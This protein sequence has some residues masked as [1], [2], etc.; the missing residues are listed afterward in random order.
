MSTGDQGRHDTAPV[1]TLVLDVTK[2]NIA[3]ANRYRDTAC[4]VAANV[5]NAAGI[6]R[7]HIKITTDDQRS[8]WRGLPDFTCYYI[9]DE[10]GCLLLARDR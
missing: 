9:D 5:V 6:F 4:F 2:S 8:Q 1:A 7:E 3:V 10:G